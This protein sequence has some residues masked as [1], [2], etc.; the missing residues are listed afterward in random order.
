MVVIV[1]GVSGA[2]K[3]TVGKLLAHRLGAHFLD[4]DDF[5]P[6]ENVEKMRGG[7]P[8]AESDRA[9]WLAQLNKELRKHHLR[10]ERVVLACSALRRS[11]REQLLEGLPAAQVV[12]LRGSRALLASRLA[13]R[14][15]HFMPPAL[16][17][18]QFEALEEPRNAVTVDVSGTPEGVVEAICAALDLKA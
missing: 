14:K 3:T 4:A 7:S 5:H 9:P 13:Q 11:H 18:T 16:L 10:G 1:M 17:D 8:L 15:G 12:Y 2:G 6:E